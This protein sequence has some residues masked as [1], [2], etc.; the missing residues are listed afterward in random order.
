MIESTKK[1]VVEEEQVDT[2]SGV[3]KEEQVDA[4]SCI[5]K[6][7]ILSLF[8]F[9][10]EKNKLMCIAFGLA[11][12]LSVCIAGT[13]ESYKNIKP[14]CDG[15][16]E[17][18]LLKPPELIKHIYE[19]LFDIYKHDIQIYDDYKLHIPSLDYKDNYIVNR[20]YLL[21]KE[22]DDYHDNYIFSI[23]QTYDFSIGF[24][25]LF[26]SMIIVDICIA[27]MIAITGYRYLIN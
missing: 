22:C 12:L 18:I 4:E 11:V 5:S 20:T 21:Y 13:I 15:N 19:L 9:K 3:S 26:V 27:T 1:T 17:G 8:K 25:V 16:Y 2:E 6:R 23:D 24:I 7:K 10:N 14:K